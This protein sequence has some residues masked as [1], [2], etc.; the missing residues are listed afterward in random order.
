[1]AEWITTKEA[2]ELTGYNAEYLRWLIREKKI[3][4]QKFGILWQVN[5]SSLL[6]YLRSAEK[7][8]DKR[9][10]AKSARD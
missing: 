5:K 3:K 8:E 4:A 2:S 7:S 9:R 6:A 10:G 1:M